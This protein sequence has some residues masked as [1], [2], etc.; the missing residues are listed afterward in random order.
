MVKL[1]NIK[2]KLTAELN[3]FVLFVLKNSFCKYLHY[4]FI[5]NKTQFETSKGS[6]LKFILWELKKVVIENF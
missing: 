2:E 4:L 6:V 3:A 1:V 5:Y